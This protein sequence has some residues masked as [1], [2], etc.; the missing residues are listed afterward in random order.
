MSD[1]HQRTGWTVLSR[2]GC[3]L[4]IVFCV[5][6]TAIAKDPEL[7]REMTTTLDATGDAALQQALVGSWWQSGWRL[8]RPAAQLGPSDIDPPI[9]ALV[10]KSDGTFSVT[11]RGG[12]AHTLDLPH[13]E[14]PDYSGRYTL[15]STTGAIRMRYENGLYRP[16]DFSGDGSYQINGATLTLTGVWFGTRQAKTK[17]DICELTFT[18]N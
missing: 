18:K 16:R 2:T 13:V 10:F 8:C 15:P 9:D 4:A 1:E 14:V 5:G 17:P 3:A 12:G 11:W 6:R 7:T